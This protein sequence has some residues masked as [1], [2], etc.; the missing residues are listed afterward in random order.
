MSMLIFQ[1]MGCGL[2]Y[3]DRRI[4]DKCEEFCRENNACSIEIARFSIELQ[5]EN[6]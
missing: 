3:H 2:H 6:T 4:A 5:K 1:C